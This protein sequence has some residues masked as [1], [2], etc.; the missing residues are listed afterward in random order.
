MGERTEHPV[1][2]AV[3]AE[4]DDPVVASRYLDWLTGRP[5]FEHSHV[6]QVL[7]WGGTG[8]EIVWLDAEPGGGTSG[9]VPGA[10]RIECR[11]EFPSRAALERYLAEGAPPLRAEG[12]R[13]FLD[14][15]GLRMSRRIGEI[16]AKIT[17]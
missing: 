17:P 8:A 14:G 10:T 6:K 7:A 16:R 3:T 11:Y 2:Y 12:K 13:L 4:I 1:M 5:P 9:A 15:G